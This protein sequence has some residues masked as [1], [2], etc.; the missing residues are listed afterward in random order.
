MRRVGLVALFLSLACA[1]AFAQAIPNGRYAGVRGYKN[2]SFPYCLPRY[3]FE[4]DISNNVVTFESDDRIWYGT[5]DQ[6]SGQIDIRASGV[7]PA[8]SQN[9]WIRGPWTQAR[10]WSAYCGEGYFT[11]IPQ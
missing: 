3:D 9:I 7:T 2:P 5:L 11:I 8:P 1:G 6:R 10:M 4:A